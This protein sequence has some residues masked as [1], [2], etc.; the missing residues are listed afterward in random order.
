VPDLETLAETPNVSFDQVRTGR[1]RT[2]HQ[3]HAVPRPM[4]D[5]QRTLGWQGRMS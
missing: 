5:H 3:R 4:G 1:D 2:F